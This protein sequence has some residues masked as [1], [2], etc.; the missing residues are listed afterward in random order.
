ME[1]CFNVRCC[2]MLLKGGI[3]FRHNQTG[4]HESG[5]RLCYVIVNLWSQKQMGLCREL[6]HSSSSN[7][8]T[9]LTELSHLPFDVQTSSNL[10]WRAQIMQLV[11]ECLI[12][13]L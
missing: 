7:L 11:S 1:N 13:F 9:I 4:V 3:L 6:N 2:I 5:V 10:S 12:L 8:V